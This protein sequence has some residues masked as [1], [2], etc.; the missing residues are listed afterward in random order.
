MSNKFTSKYPRIIFDKRENSVN[1]GLAKKLTVEEYYDL[2]HHT[3][4]LSSLIGDGDVPIS[5]IMESINKLI[6]NVTRLE[7]TIEYQ[8]TVIKRYEEEI[9][10][11]TNIT[12]SHNKTITELNQVVNNQNEIIQNITNEVIHNGITIGDWDVEKPGDQDINGDD[13]GKFM[14]LNMTEI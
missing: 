4:D 14:G 3:H 12:E 1:D 13:L 11:L 7:E 6:V 2:L 5:D 9:T 10:H 8:E